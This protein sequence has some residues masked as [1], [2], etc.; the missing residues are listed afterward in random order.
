[1]KYIYKPSGLVVEVGEG[2]SLPSFLYEPL[3][4]EKKAEEP[5]KRVRKAAKQE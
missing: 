3:K 1:M 4:E 5:K 2:A